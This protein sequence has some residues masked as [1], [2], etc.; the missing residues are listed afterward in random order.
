M[1]NTTTISGIT[2]TLYNAI[3]SVTGFTKDIQK[4]IIILDKI[5]YN[6]LDYLVTSIGNYA[7]ESC[8]GLTTIIIPDSITSI[9]KH[10][11]NNCIRLASVIIPDSITYIGDG[12]FYMCSKL[13][14]ATI[15]NNVTFIGD[16]AFYNCID[17]TYVIFN[18]Q[19][20]LLNVEGDNIFKNTNIETVLFFLTTNESDL[21]NGMINLKTQINTNNV[22]V[23]YVYSL[24]NN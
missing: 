10:A 20:K 19:K 22:N 7:F 5:Q 23:Y 2:Y 4:N 16:F 11:F 3:A 13:T 1:S 15:G 24:N 9:G 8:I 14:S 17:L 21:S 12:A 18:D 6:G